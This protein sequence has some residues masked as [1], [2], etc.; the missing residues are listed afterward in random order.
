MTESFRGQSV[1]FIVN[2]RVGNRFETRV[3]ALSFGGGR[4]SFVLEERERFSTFVDETIRSRHEPKYFTKKLMERVSS[5]VTIKAGIRREFKLF[6]RMLGAHR[7][8][9]IIGERD[10]LKFLS[11]LLTELLGGY[12]VSAIVNERVGVIFEIRVFA[13]R[14]KGQRVSFILDKGMRINHMLPFYK[15]SRD[16]EEPGHHHDEASTM[17][18]VGMDDAETHV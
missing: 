4:A 13:V 15:R 5:L 3:F 7:V 2:E 6:C 16:H 1:F 12:R 10:R 17:A 8:F 11:K 14:F 18:P 9:T